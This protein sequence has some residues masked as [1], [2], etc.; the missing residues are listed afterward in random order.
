MIK[1]LY[2][3]VS[4][5]VTNASRQQVLTHNIANLDTPGFKQILTTVQDF[6]K[7]GVVYSPGNLLKS[8]L[9]VVGNLGLGSEYGPEFIDFTQGGLQLTSNQYDMAI[10]G[11]GL[12][13][14][15]TPN[16]ERYTRDGRFLRDTKNNLVTVDGY[17]VLNASGQPITLPDGDIEVA[18]DGTISVNGKQAGK[19]GLVVFQNPSTELKHDA[20][21]LFTGPAKSTGKDLGRVVQGALEMSNA[22][23]TQLMAQLVDVQRSYEAAQKMVQNED[24]LTGKTISSLGRIS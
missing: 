15:K 5:M 1:G 7:T 24:Q 23:P 20:G 6:M 22:N 11:N 16:G 9:T 3:A 10:D 17:K 18:P 13:R 4:A 19:L 12:F 21:N 8:N 14:V 2:A